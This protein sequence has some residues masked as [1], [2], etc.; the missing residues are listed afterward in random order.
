[1]QIA[2]LI[3]SPFIDLLSD[4]CIVIIIQLDLHVTIDP[5]YVELNLRRVILIRV[6]VN[7]QI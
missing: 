3:T 7:R 4:Y 5:V 1:M 2:E 6:L